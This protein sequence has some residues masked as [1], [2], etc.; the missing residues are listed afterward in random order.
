MLTM[1]GFPT[2]MLGPCVENRAMGFNGG[3]PRIM[4]A[5][6]LIEC[7]LGLSD[8][9]F[10]PLALL[11]LG[12]ELRP[13]LGFVPLLLPL[14]IQCSFPGSSLSSRAPRC[15]WGA[16]DLPSRD[17]FRSVRSALSVSDVSRK[18]FVHCFGR[19][20]ILV[21]LGGRYPT[22]SLAVWSEPWSFFSHCRLSGRCR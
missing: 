12:G 19:S 11:G 9:S 13:A 7:R 8:R 20:S 4:I 5:L 17:S 3:C 16:P 10:T 14:K 6:G 1:A 15:W 2:L 18:E 22:P 21:V